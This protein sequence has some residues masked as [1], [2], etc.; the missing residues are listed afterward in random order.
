MTAGITTG[1]TTQTAAIERSLAGLP[2]VSLE[3][4]L[5]R[6]AL[7]TRVDRKYLLPTAEAAR[8]LGRLD[9]GTR[10]LEVAGHRTSAYSSVYF[11]TPEHLLYRLTAQQRRRRLKV[12]TRTYLL[13]GGCF[14]ETKTRDGR[15][16]TVK[17]RIPHRPEDGER[18]T[19][20]GR[21]HVLAR[22]EGLGRPVEP[23]VDRLEPALWIRYERSS[24]LLPC[25]SRATIDSGLHWLGLD[26]LG[27]RERTVRLRGL[28]VLETKSA[29]RTSRLDRELWRSGH[30]PL[31]L[32][33]FGLGTAV[34]H[35]DLPHNRWSRTLRRAFPP[36]PHNDPDHSS[37]PDPRTPSCDA[38]YDEPRP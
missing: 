10:V 36:P 32:S 34:L 8:I 28:V 12:R 22:L 3:E 27:P 35:P 5:T 2:T 1:S 15:G 25:G 33:K 24:V 9:P 6:A 14:L 23:V 19:A 26:P 31:A 7:L 20:S 17:E 11:D 37:T 16:T 29:G 21:E 4:V 13:T 18:L 38:S 30:R